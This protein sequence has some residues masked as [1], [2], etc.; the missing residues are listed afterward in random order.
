MVTF[1]HVTNLLFIH[2]INLQNQEVKLSKFKKNISSLALYSSYQVFI[3]RNEERFNQSFFLLPPY[4]FLQIL[5]NKVESKT[6]KKI[7]SD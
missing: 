4:L 3:T 7:V 2:Y 6:I 1:Q 5:I